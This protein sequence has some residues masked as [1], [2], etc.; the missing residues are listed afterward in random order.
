MPEQKW[1]LR[2]G[3]EEVC[4]PVLCQRLSVEAFDGLHFSERDAL[5][6]VANVNQA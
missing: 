3:D 4:F 5:V 2:I 6:S 1:K